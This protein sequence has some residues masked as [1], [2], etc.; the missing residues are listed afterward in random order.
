MASVVNFYRGPQSQIDAISEL[1]DGRLYFATDSKKIQMDCVHTDS[2]NNSFNKRITF[3]G[4]T[5]IYYGKKAFGEDEPGF[6]GEEAQKKATIALQ[7]HG[8]AQSEARKEVLCSDGFVTKENSLVQVA[9]IDINS[10]TDTLTDIEPA[11][12]TSFI[13][14]KVQ[15]YLMKKLLKQ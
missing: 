2:L 3:G 7:N 15:H 14:N 12:D 8:G 13:V 6:S 5:G 11:Y 10:I 4:S 9:H 1:E